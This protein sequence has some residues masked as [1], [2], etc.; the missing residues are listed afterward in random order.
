MRKM[1][2]IEGDYWMKGRDDLALIYLK[3]WLEVFEDSWLMVYEIVFTLS[4]SSY[5]FFS[6]SGLYALTKLLLP[7]PLTKLWYYFD[8]TTYFKMLKYI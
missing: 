2:I 6:L 3:D 5:A 8:S 4:F 7:T 1:C